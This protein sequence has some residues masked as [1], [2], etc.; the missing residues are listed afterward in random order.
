MPGVSKHTSSNR[1]VRPMLCNSAHT[2]TKRPERPLSTHTGRRTISP[3]SLLHLSTPRYPPHSL[4]TSAADTYDFLVQVDRGVGIADDHLDL[5]A[6][7][8][9]G[10]G[11]LKFDLAVLG[12]ELHC[13][14]GRQPAR[15]RHCRIAAHLFLAGV[16]NDARRRRT[17]RYRRQYGERVCKIDVVVRAVVHIAE[18][19]PADLHFGYA[20]LLRT[21]RKGARATAAHDRDAVAGCGAGPSVC[22]DGCDRT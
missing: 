18:N 3:L 1:L 8:G 20:G 19:G 16:D 17:A 2:Q 22:R 21:I 10:A 11:L 13:A 9:G 5:V 15:R 7:P 6:D 12:R 14:D 4:N